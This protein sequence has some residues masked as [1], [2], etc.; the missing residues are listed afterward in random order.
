MLSLFQNIHINY[1]FS[2]FPADLGFSQL[3]FSQASS[4]ACNASLLLYISICCMSY[5]YV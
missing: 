3:Y 4:K 1:W 5:H 2:K